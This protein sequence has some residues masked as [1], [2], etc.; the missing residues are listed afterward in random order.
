[1]EGK[2]ESRVIIGKVEKVENP[3]PDPEKEPTIGEMESDGLPR[4]AYTR[5]RVFSG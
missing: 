4:G 5:M 2:K 1:V 3:D